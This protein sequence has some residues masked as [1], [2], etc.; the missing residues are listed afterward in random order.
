MV[1]W[2]LVLQALHVLVVVLNCTEWRRLSRAT[3]LEEMLCGVNS[4]RMRNEVEVMKTVSPC[5]K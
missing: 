4:P 5:L 1:R 2:S 3:S